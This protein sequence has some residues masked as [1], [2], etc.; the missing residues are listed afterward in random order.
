MYGWVHSSLLILR[1]NFSSCRSCHL[2]KRSASLSDMFVCFLLLTSA[3]FGSMEGGSQ[4]QGQDGQLGL[5]DVER[6]I[7]AQNNPSRPTNA[8]AVTSSPLSSS[9]IDFAQAFPISMTTGSFVR[10]SERMWIITG[11]Y[12]SLRRLIEEVTPHFHWSP[13]PSILQDLIYNRTWCRFQGRR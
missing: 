9:T 4:R 11:V 3:H 10:K 6:G 13:K 12:M 5:F 2:D 1:P 7:D 8:A